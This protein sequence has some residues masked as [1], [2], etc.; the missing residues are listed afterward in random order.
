M[1]TKSW[2]IS[3]VSIGN[4]LAVIWHPMSLKSHRSGTSL[5]VF[6]R[7]NTK[8]DSKRWHETFKYGCLSQGFKSR[9]PKRDFTMFYCLWFK[10]KNG[11]LLIQKFDFQRRG[12]K[13]ECFQAEWDPTKVCLA[14]QVLSGGRCLRFLCFSFILKAFQQKGS[15][16]FSSQQQEDAW[17]LHELQVV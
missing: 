11:Y 2:T 13:V 4:R 14:S 10:R 5:I 1:I 8:D 9:K 17:I 15:S 16:P 6:Y 3:S 12:R 7:E